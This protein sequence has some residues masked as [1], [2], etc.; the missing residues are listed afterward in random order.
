MSNKIIQTLHMG[1]LTWAWYGKIQIIQK[2]DIFSKLWE[3]L[4]GK[5]ESS[6]NP[7]AFLSPFRRH[8]SFSSLK[9]FSKWWSFCKF[10]WRFGWSEGIFCDHKCNFKKTPILFTPQRM[11]IIFLM[12]LATKKLISDE[13][14]NLSLKL[15]LF[16][17]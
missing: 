5:G 6:H 13:F 17:V 12:F 1:E 3:L 4:S 10:S 9:H 2:C 16:V 11:E 15:E 8:S 7:M 14:I